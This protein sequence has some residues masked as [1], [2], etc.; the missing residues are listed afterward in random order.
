MCMCVCVCACACALKQQMM[1]ANHF[2]GGKINFHIPT[3]Y[4]NGPV[5][6]RALLIFIENSVCFCILCHSLCGL[7]RLGQ[8]SEVS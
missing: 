8:I 4:S 6:L 7:E 1:R 3:N 5:S 2:T